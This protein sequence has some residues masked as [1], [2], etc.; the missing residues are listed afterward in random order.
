MNVEKDLE[1]V[2]QARPYIRTV[3]AFLFSLK[4]PYASVQS[5]YGRADMFL[6]Q[7]EKDIEA[8]EDLL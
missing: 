6:D 7:L 5:C 4:E 1:T 2:R 3:M 8:G